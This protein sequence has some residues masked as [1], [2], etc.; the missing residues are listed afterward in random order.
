ML[1]ITVFE[2]SAPVPCVP[3]LV[4]SK[5]HIRTIVTWLRSILSSTRYGPAALGNRFKYSR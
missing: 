4:H 1:Y 3:V 5:N 2:P